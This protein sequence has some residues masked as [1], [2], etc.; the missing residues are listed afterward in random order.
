MGMLRE[1][2]LALR[3]YEWVDHIDCCPLPRW[4]S[5]I[6]TCRQQEGG[7]KLPGLHIQRSISG[8]EKTLLTAKYRYKAGGQVATTYIV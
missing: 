4:G 7:T 8:E 2:R 5:T 3:E 6:N 1:N